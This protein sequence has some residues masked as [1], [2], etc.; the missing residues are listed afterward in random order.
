MLDR[1]GQSRMVFLIQIV[2]LSSTA[3]SSVS[4]VA[5]FDQIYLLAKQEQKC[6][7]SH[8]LITGIFQ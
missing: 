1:L 5:Q 3:P 8:I 7:E 4:D 6:Q 2:I